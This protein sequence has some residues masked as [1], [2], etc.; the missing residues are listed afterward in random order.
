M[1]LR[2]YDD[3][4]CH[5]G[6]GVPYYMLRELAVLQGIKH[7]HIASLEMISLAKDELHVFFP[8]VDKTLH[9][10][11]NPTSDPSGGR[12]LPEPQVRPTPLGFSLVYDAE[13]RISDFALVRATGIPRRTYTMEVVTLWYRP[14]EILM[15][16]RSYSPA[17]DIWSIGCI[18]AEMAQGKPLFTGISEIDQLFQIFS[19]LATPTAATWPAFTTLPNYRFEFP[20]W[21]SRP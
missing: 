6:E 17:V 14:P 8:Y 2:L 5:T 19:K 10:V 16:V 4:T 11:I 20:N 18:F 15:G 1:V 12:V 13:L 9:E 7:P 21:T 3:W